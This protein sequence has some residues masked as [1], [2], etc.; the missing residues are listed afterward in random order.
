MNE[1]G[2][3]GVGVWHF[4]ESDGTVIRDD[5]QFAND[6]VAH[7]TRIVTGRFGSARRFNGE[8]DYVTIPHHQNSPLDFGL[9]QSFTI[10]AWFLTEADGVQ[11]IVRK[12]LAPVPGYALRVYNG[13]VQGIIGNR[14]DG[15]PPDALVK[16]TSRQLYNDGVWHKAVLVRDREKRKLFL[17]VDNV[18]ATDPV[19]D[20]FPFPLVSDSPLAI[21]AWD[22]Y[23]GTEHFSGLIDEIRILRC[24][25]TTR[26]FPR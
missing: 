7:G 1:Q 9:N 6:G 21:G 24:A 26:N 20:R 16:I 15:M 8:G 13:H 17:Y 23:G 5:S 25:L 11:E 14:E 3:L 12:G 2:C 4:D 19:E 18:E 22:V 10:E